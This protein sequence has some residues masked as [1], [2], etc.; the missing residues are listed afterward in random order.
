MSPPPR[1]FGTLTVTVHVH[2][3]DRQRAFAP[4]LAGTRLSA[5]LK[6]EAVQQHIGI[7]HHA[8]DSS[9]QV[10]LVDVC[11]PGVSGVLDFLR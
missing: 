8:H 4:V 3:S 2:S 1:A 5:C 11:Q 6:D 9:A 7:K 10:F